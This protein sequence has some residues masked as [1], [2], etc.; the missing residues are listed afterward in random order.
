MSELQIVHE[1]LFNIVIFLN[2]LFYFLIILG[3]S[4]SAPKYIS[5]FHFYLQIYISLFLLYRFNPFRKI[6][7]NELD[8]KVAFSAGVFII[9]TTAIGKFVANYLKKYINKESINNQ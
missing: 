4:S 2:Y 7:F 3:L 8:R 6:Q 9:T 1:R 5:T